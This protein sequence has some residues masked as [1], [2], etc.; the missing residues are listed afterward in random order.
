MIPVEI[1]IPDLSRRKS[2]R[3]SVDIETG[4]QTNGFGKMACRVA[5]LSTDGARLMSYSVLPVD[6]VIVLNLPILGPVQAQIIWS[7]EFEAGC[8]FKTPLQQGELDVVLRKY[9]LPTMI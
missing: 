6:T 5:D 3:S 7:K 1:T 4:M 8:Q 9:G 2:K